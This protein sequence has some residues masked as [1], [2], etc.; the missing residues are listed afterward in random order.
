MKPKIFSLGRPVGVV[1]LFLCIAVS[2]RA[3]QGDLKLEAQ[4]I[5]GTNDSPTKDG[6]NLLVKPNL[7]KKLKRLPFKWE[8]YYVMHT[9]S[10]SAAENQTAKVTMST[11]CEIAVKNIGN[12]R[13]ELSLVG[14]GKSVGKITQ[15]LDKGQTLVTGGNADNLTGWFIVL[16][17]EE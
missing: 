6:T 8:R 9:Q 2:A 3:A 12:S 14:K 10:F 11:D 5:W 7:E 15:S 4:L 16:R 1:F 13:V 17:Q